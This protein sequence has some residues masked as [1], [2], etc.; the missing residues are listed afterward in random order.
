MTMKKLTALLSAVVMLVGLFCLPVSAGSNDGFNDV[1]LGWPCDHENAK[2]CVAKCPDCLQAL[3]DVQPHTYDDGQDI[4]CNVCGGYRIVVVTAPKTTY[5]KEGA[6]A[7]ITVKALGDGLTYQWYIRNASASKYSKSSIKTNTYSVAIS[8]K[9]HGRRI[10]CILTDKHGNTLQTATVLVRRQ[11]TITS[12]S[13]TARYAKEGAKVSATVTAIGDGLKYT[14]Y[15][16][17][18]GASKYA[19]SSV[20]KATYST[21]MSDKVKGRRVYCVVKDKY[22]KTAQS[23]TF[24]LRERVSIIK[25][26]ATSIYAKNGATAK[27]T[28]QA[29]GDG[30]KYTWY[31]KDAGKSKYSKSSI[32]KAT[33]SVKMSSKVNGRRIYCIVTDKYGKK[34]QSKTMILKKK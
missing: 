10:Y 27:A 30:L 14:W 5:A 29:S 25:E 12:E 26:P 8:D 33:Y 11:A 3:E 17:N 15:V 21:T 9:S 28:I 13:A 23:K 4:D 7:K 6:T 24:L 2:K 32:T 19:K 34:V 22:G 16:K 18:E 20:T 31:I 1:E